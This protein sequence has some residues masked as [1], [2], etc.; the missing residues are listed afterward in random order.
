MKKQNA[1]TL[2][3]KQHIF[4]FKYLTQEKL[5]LLVGILGLLAPFLLSDY[6]VND[7]LIKAMIFGLLAVSLD[8][9]WGYTGILSF[10]HGAFFGSGAY[11]MGIILVRWASPMA[12]PSAVVLGIFGPTFLAMVVGFLLFYT[13]T[14]ELYI[15]V[16]T[17]SLSLLFPQ[18]VLRV[19]QWTGGMNGLSGI[20]LY[21]FS[22]K[23]KY[24]LIFFIIAL[25]VYAV[26][27][28][29]RSDFG[30]LLIAVRDNEQRIRFLGFSTSFIRLVAFTLSGTIAGVASVLYPPQNGFISQT[31]PGLVMSTMAIVWVAIGGR[32]TLIGPFLGAVLINWVSP[33]LNARFPHVWQLILGLL[34]IVVIIFIPG[35]IYSLVLRFVRTRDTFE[36]TEKAARKAPTDSRHVSINDLKVNYGTL[37]VLKGVDLEMISGKLLC[38]IGPNG[39]GKSTLVNA[40]TGSVYPKS[41]Q[42]LLGETPIQRK[43]PQISTRFG[44]AR[45]FQTAN[46]FD[47]LSVGENLFLATCHGRL[48]SPFKR[49]THIPL[50]MSVLRILELS[51]LNRNLSFDVNGLGHGERK[52]LELLMVLCTEPNMVLL[53]EPTAG[54]TTAERKEVGVLLRRLVQDEGLGLLLIE[55]D[56]DFVTSIADRIAVLADGRILVNGPVDRVIHNE[57]VRELYLGEKTYGFVG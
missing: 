25:V 42:I 20:P 40:M 23:V 33:F 46:L 7:V 17:L 49:S 21:P 26:F 43:P 5:M 50:P 41:G 1:D 12:L 48:P 8:I 35:G 47:T 16:I 39:A 10:G 32:G 18:F 53:D 3:E 22:I 36:L 19:P 15:V 13:K 28:I 2:G 45:T 34:F 24:Y 14:S 55:H 31:L 52:W 56:I 4:S 37:E 38:L 29:V 57:K 11:I 51:G 54:L 6:V 27:R 9:A 30:R 44:L